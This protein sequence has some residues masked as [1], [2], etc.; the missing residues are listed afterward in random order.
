MKRTNFTLIELLVVIAIIAILASML[1]PAL[2]KARAAA[3]ATKCLSNTKQW[4]LA[5]QMYALDNGDYATPWSYRGTGEAFAGSGWVAN[6]VEYIGGPAWDPASSNNSALL[7]CP[8]ATS[9]AVADAVKAP[10]YIY[11]GILTAST[12]HYKLRQLG[13]C[14][15]PSQMVLMIDGNCFAYQGA[16]YAMMDFPK[17]LVNDQLDLYRHNGRLSHMYVDGHAAPF[18]LFSLADDS[19]RIWEDYKYITVFGD[20]LWP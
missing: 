4:G 20:M 19:V 13:N 10:N 3:Q 17:N 15:R 9:V 12:D 6:M 7:Y 14:T 2:S 1:L 18:A 8:A 16:V 11:S 5:V